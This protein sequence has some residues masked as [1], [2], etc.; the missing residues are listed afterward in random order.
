MKCMKRASSAAIANSSTRN[1]SRSLTIRN[2]ESAGGP[3]SCSMGPRASFLLTR[4][5]RVHRH[6]ELRDIGRRAVFQ[7]GDLRR[8]VL[9]HLID[10]QDRVHR[11]EGALDAGE[12]T[13]DALFGGV[14]HHGGSLTEQQLL[15]LD[16]TEQFPVAD[17]PGV[18][19]V[20]LALIHEHNAENVTGCHGSRM[21]RC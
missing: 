19:L 6:G 21:G 16:E 5:S 15:H 13:L 8:A 20:N 10:A 2:A 9:L 12:L 4:W 3:V 1:R 7:H 14:E 17:A 11:Q 18:Y